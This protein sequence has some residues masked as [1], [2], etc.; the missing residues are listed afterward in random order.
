VETPKDRTHTD[1]D[2]VWVVGTITEG[3]IVTIGAQSFESTDGTF[4]IKVRLPEAV[5]L[6]TVVGSDL[7]GNEVSIDRLVFISDDTKGIT[8]NAF[9]DNNCN[10]LLL[11]MLIAIIAIGIIVAFLW[12]GE[13]VFDRREQALAAV[14]EED[15]IEMDKP[16]LEPTSGY[17]QYDPTSPTGRKPE[18]EERDEDEEFVS[19]ADFR[20][21]YQE[22]E[23][24]VEEE[25]HELVIEDPGQP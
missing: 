24:V 4:E 9:L 2:F 7:A 6:I 25:E 11:I 14:M 22:H 10:S 16:H 17:L 3:D 1:S 5:N 19:M 13:D 23:P 21:G 12:R 15:N 20:K 8:G 18:F